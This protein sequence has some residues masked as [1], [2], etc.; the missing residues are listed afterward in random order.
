MMIGSE[1]N[2][3]NL[4]G[5]QVAHVERLLSRIPG[6]RNVVNPMC[7]S[8]RH[9]ARVCG[10]QPRSREVIHPEVTE[11]LPFVSTE[12]AAQ[13]GVRTRDRSTDRSIDRAIGILGWIRTPV[14]SPTPSGKW[15]SL[16]IES[17][18]D[19]CSL[20]QVGRS[21]VDGQKGPN[22]KRRKVKLFVC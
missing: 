13:A 20:D 3:R 10:L 18:L 9:I 17:Q 16:I 5:V 15:G 6:C 19:P 2:A 21:Q 8:Q 1:G 14:F 11:T 12:P 4:L 22:E 7:Q